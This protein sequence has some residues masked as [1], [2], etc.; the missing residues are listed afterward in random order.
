MNVHNLA[1]ILTPN[2]FR[3]FELTANDLI[4]AQHLVET[5]KIM[6]NEYRDIFSVTS[7]EDEEGEDVEIMMISPNKAP[8]NIEE[9]MVGQVFQ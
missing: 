4:F 7:E 8:K 9:D 2:I 1:T 3:P 5:F 6:I